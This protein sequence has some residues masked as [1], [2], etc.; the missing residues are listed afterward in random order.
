MD[1]GIKFHD[2]N[3]NEIFFNPF[4]FDL[5]NRNMLVTGTVAPEKSV[6]VNKIVHSLIEDHPVVILDKGGSFKKLT[7]YH[8]GTDLKHGIDPFQFK[9]PYLRE[10]ILSVID[11]S[12]FQS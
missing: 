8:G 9:D 12:R 7:L 1:Q 2:S 4:N 11:G 6:L 3:A 10:I 5:K